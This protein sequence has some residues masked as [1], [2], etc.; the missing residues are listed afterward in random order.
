MWHIC[1]TRSESWV[2]TIMREE[3]MKRGEGFKTIEFPIPLWWMNQINVHQ[4]FIFQDPFGLS[5]DGIG[6]AA[7]YYYIEDIQYDIRGKKLRIK[8][9]DLQYLLRQYLL[10]G[11]ETVLT[12]DEANYNTASDT[13]RMYAFCCNEITEKFQNGDP[14]K[15]FANEIL[16]L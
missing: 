4:S 12:G 10:L 8:A 6:E 15:I 7:H 5:A 1:W 3:L 14:G 13:S 2:R 11:D 16:G 9:V